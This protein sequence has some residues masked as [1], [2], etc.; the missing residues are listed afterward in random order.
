V[1]GDEPGGDA[2]V[3]VLAAMAT[4]IRPLVRALSLRPGRVGGATVRTGNAGSTPVVTTVIGVG[5]E[6]ARRATGQLLDAARFSRVLVVGVSGGIDPD[7]AIGTVLAPDLVI[8]RWSGEE[9]R[10]THPPAASRQGT[11]VTSET[12]VTD[13]AFVADLRS[14]G[15]VAV[16]METAAV[17]AECAARGVPWGVLRVISDRPSDDLVDDVVLGLVRPDG[18][19]DGAAVARLLLRRPWEVR[20]LARLAR[21]T[22]TALSAITRAAVDDLKG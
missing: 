6:A 20:R 11:L 4:E 3:A 9:H 16:D 12:L 17:A 10:P 13:A 22:R 14:R 15:V 1:A 19:T 8:A 7:L 5:P 18:S 21:D 2:A